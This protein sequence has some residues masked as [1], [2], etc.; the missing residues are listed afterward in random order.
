LETLK[1]KSGLLEDFDGVARVKK[2]QVP[3]GGTGMYPGWIMPA[4]AP[5][6]PGCPWTFGERSFLLPCL[7]SRSRDDV[8]NHGFKTLRRVAQGVSGHCVTAT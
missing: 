7:V 2:V 8:S 5:K 3:A 4:G 6:A 1:A